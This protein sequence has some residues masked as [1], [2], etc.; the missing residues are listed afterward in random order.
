MVRNNKSDYT[1]EII[2]RKKAYHPKLDKFLEFMEDRMSSSKIYRYQNESNKVWAAFYMFPE[3]MAEFVQFIRDET[4]FDLE[5]IYLKIMDDGL[6]RINPIRVF[7][8]ADQKTL[9]T[10]KYYY[11]VL[12]KDFNNTYTN[13]IGFCHPPKTYEESLEIIARN[14][15]DKEAEAEVKV[16]KEV[17]S[18]KRECNERERERDDFFF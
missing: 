5:D 14:E 9:A 8:E 6:I 10:M 16:K 1:K 11:E 7:V 12:D 17:K 3:F 13:E 15:L 4:D 2:Q 18:E